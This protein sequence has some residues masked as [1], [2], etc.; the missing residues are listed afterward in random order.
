[1][2]KET[3]FWTGPGVVHISG[4]E[5]GEHDPLPVDKIDKATLA[6][7][8]VEGKV[9][10][11]I[12]AAAVDQ[13]ARIAEL[14]QELSD[15]RTERTQVQDGLTKCQEELA[16][17]NAR[18]EELIGQV[19]TANAKVDELVEQVEAL[20]DPDGG[21]KDGGKPGD[22]PPLTGG[23]AGPGAKGAGK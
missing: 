10:V 23:G 4:K 19:T 7:W 9:G 3:L 5:Y 22:T 13:S 8:K 17:A 21:G 11:K 16:T 20:T 1:M 14:G 12:S 6:K 18:A 2:A 15:T